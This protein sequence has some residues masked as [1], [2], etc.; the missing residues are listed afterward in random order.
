MSVERT[1]NRPFGGVTSMVALLGWLWLLPAV[2][3]FATLPVV[4]D[5]ALD[6]RTT[7]G[8]KLF[9]ATVA[10]D[11]G[12]ADK[13]DEGG[14]VRLLLYYVNDRERAR[15]LADRLV[16]AGAIRGAPVAVSLSADIQLGAFEKRPPV[17]LFVAEEPLEADGLQR[18][19]DYARRHRILLFSPFRGHVER[20]AGAGLFI[21]AK[22]RPYVNPRTLEENGITLRRF[23][24][25]IAKRAEGER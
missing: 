16:E 20:G 1:Q 11:T 15:E 12:L 7:L 5:E 4:A 9:R 6:R 22:V 19:I 18:L 2:V 14:A 10:A 17:A 24:M 23:F 3:T 13:R 8:I 25:R 21:A